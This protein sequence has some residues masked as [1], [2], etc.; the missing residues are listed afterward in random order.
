[1]LKDAW[2]SILSLIQ[3]TLDS[4]LFSVWIRPLEAEVTEGTLRVLAPNDFVASWVRERLSPAIQEAAAQVLGRDV[5]L[6]V[7]VRKKTA[8]PKPA[9]TSSAGAPA[10][11]AAPAPRPAPAPEVQ[12]GL[13]ILQLP[14]TSTNFRWRFR[15]ED[16][17][18][19]PC[20]ELACAASKSLCDNNLPS[21]RL[22]L[23]AG[24]GLGKTHL[25]HSIGRKLCDT[26]NRQPRVACLT[27]EEFATRFVLAMRAR[28]LTRFKALFRESVDVLL[29]E[30]VHFFHG[31]EKMQ[32]ELLAT[33]NALHERGCKVVLTSS[34]LPREIEGLGSQLVSRLCSGV[35]T[36]LAQ[37]DLETRRRIVDRKARAMGQPVAPDIANLLA[38]RITTDIRQLESCLNNLVLKARLLNQKVS[39]EL[40]WDV[41]AHYAQTQ[42]SPDFDHIITF[43]CKHYGI[44]ERQLKSKSRK[45]HIV[46]ARNTAFYLARMHTDLSLASLGE[47]LGRKHSTV[48]K[49]ITNI[50]REIAQQTPLGRQLEQ[51]ADRLAG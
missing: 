27:A 6:E 48:L 40:A 10:L 8:A 15:F 5:R 22:F 33:L 7:G 16:F 45:Q 31:K 34:F 4:G 13:P 37:P 12:T 42:A 2:N 26:A 30:E 19:G 17:V 23:S 39:A 3:N 32:D 47:R 50:Q 29:L 24:P 25:L 35:I 14:G 38:E 51:F 49:G 21:D 9:L 11:A 18:V 41:L 20:N 1:M 28:E 36:Q 43:V 44:D 46:L